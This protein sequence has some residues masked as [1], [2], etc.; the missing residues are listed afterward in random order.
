VNHVINSQNIVTGLSADLPNFGL[1]QIINHMSKRILGIT[2]IVL[3]VVMMIYTGFNY[4]TREKVVDL[5]PLTIHAK[6]NHPVQWSPI[7]GMILLI[8]G[9]AVMVTPRIKGS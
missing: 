4:V 1:I 3:G 9:I 2:L 8:G 7:A 6:K 5:G